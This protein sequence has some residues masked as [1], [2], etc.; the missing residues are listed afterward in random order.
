[1]IIAVGTPVDQDGL[2]NMTHITD[3]IHSIAESINGYTLIIIRST[4]PVGTNQK[5]EKFLRK[6]CP[7]KNFDVVSNPEFLRT[8]TFVQDFLNPDRIVFG[9]D[10]QKAKELICQIYNVHKKNSI[11]FI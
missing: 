4:V 5:I 2:P 1:M 3:A 9:T 6:R 10:S 11:P 7:D 8:G